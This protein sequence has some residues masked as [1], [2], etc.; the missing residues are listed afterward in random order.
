MSLIKSADVPKH[1]ADRLR[2]RRI[3]ARL[4]GAGGKPVVPAKALDKT[5]PAAPVEVPAT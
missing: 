5:T 1:M 2:S 4:A 3:A